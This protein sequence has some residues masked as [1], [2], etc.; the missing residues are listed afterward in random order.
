M[1]VM[2]SKILCGIKM[3]YED[4]LMWGNVSSSK[5]KVNQYARTTYLPIHKTCTLFA[6]LYKWSLI[7]Y[8]KT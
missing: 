7:E 6:Y 3:I 2:R 4:F 8:H 1:H 5:T